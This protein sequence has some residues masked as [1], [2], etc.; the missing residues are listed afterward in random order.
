MYRTIRFR[1]KILPM[2]MHEVLPIFTGVVT[3]VEPLHIFP[4]LTCARQIM[5]LVVELVPKSSRMSYRIRP[6]RVVEQDPLPLGGILLVQMTFAI[7]SA[8][9]QRH[10]F[11]HDPC[12]GPCK[13]H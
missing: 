3:P 13:G 4:K 11:V 6:R 9:A 5:E 8:H 2:M 10:S 7:L 1:P 12:R